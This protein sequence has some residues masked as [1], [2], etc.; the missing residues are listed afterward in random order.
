MEFHIDSSPRQGPVF[1]RSIVPGSKGGSVPM[2]PLSTS[3]MLSALT[4][5]LC[6]ISPWPSDSQQ[7]HLESR[8]RQLCTHSSCIVQA[9]G[10]NTMGMSPGLT[11]YTFHSNRA[12]GNGSTSWPG[13]LRNT[14][15]ECKGTWAVSPQWSTLG[16]LAPDTLL[17]FWCSGLVVGR[18]PQG[19]LNG[20]PLC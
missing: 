2:P 17:P 6:Q 11:A 12:S 13:W 20:I 7:C 15:S 8:W 4:L 3:L 1:G 18:W 16:R 19:S 9:C 14:V 5:P 10:L